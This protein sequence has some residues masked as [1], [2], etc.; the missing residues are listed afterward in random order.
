MWKFD[1][2]VVV[3]LLGLPDIKTTTPPKLSFRGCSWHSHCDANQFCAT[4]CLTGGCIPGKGKKK[5]FCQPCDK[6]VHPTDSVTRGCE[7]CNSA[8]MLLTIICCMLFVTVFA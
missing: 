1:F 3:V 7:I 2:S 4:K 5:K 8:G 6:C